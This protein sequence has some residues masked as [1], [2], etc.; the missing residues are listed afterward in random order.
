VDDLEAAKRHGR[1]VAR[2]DAYPEIFHEEPGLSLLPPPVRELE[3]ME[4]CLRAVPDFVN[5]HP[6]DDTATEEFTVPAASGRSKPVPP[7]VEDDG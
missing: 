2:P 7:W 3:L 5:R 4:G 6:Q 1:H